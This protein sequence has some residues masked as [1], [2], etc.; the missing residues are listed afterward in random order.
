MRDDVLVTDGELRIG[1]HYGLMG[2]QIILERKSIGKNKGI[3]LKLTDH[4]EII[5]I[6]DIERRALLQILF[7]V[8]KD[9]E[10]IEKICY[11]MSVAMTRAQAFDTEEE[12]PPSALSA[13]SGRNH[14][15]FCALSDPYGAGTFEYS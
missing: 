15:G 14:Y 5:E 10:F 11:Y 7:D 3:R 9:K 8:D 6:N 1:K 4:N 13:R 2:G 12:L